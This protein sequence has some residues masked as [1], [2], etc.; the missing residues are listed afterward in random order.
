MT[1]LPASYGHG[2]HRKR[3]VV[4][5]GRPARN[6]TFSGT[7][8]KSFYDDPRNGA[9]PSKLKRPTASIIRKSKDADDEFDVPMSDDEV[10]SALSKSKKNNKPPT[11]T[12]PLSARGDGNDRSNGDVDSASPRKRK[13]TVSQTAQSSIVRP[14]A[15]VNKSQGVKTETE[16]V[17]VESAQPRRSRRQVATG[18]DST[19]APSS[20]N[21][22]SHVTHTTRSMGLPT[23]STCP[24]SLVVASPTSPADS[25]SSISTTPKQ[26]KLWHE[27]LLSD[28]PD[29]DVQNSTPNP[30][31][32]SPHRILNQPNASMSQPLITNVPGTAKARIVDRLKRKTVAA[33]RSDESSED[34]ANEPLEGMPSQTLELPRTSVQS[35]PQESTQH[36]QSQSRA[37]RQLSSTSQGAQKVTYARS[38]TY[39]QDSL[40]DMIFGDLPI[41]ATERPIAS[42]RRTKTS[43]R[44]IS[45]SKVSINHDSDEESVQGIRSIHDLRAAGHK[46]RFMDDVTRL[47]DDIKNPKPSTRSQRRMALMELSGTL[48]DSEFVSRFIEN[49]FDAS[50]IAQF[51]YAGMDVL[52]DMLLCVVLT[53]IAQASASLLQGGV[54]DFLTSYLDET[55]EINQIAR[56]RKSNM[57]KVAQSDYVDFME[58]FRSS[59]VWQDCSPEYLSPSSVA[60][61]SIN[62]IVVAHRRNKNSGTILSPHTASKLVSLA[63]NHTSGSEHTSQAVINRAL[64]TLEAA[65]TLDVDSTSSD[66]WSVETLAQLAA[67]LPQFLSMS[68]PSQELALRFCCSVTND[69][70]DNSSVFCEPHTIQLV[71]SLIID[72]FNSRN[73]SV[74]TELDSDHDLLVLALGLMIN[75]AGVS[76]AAREYA[77][78]VKDEG[79]AALV[80]IFVKGQKKAAESQSEEEMQAHIPYAWLSV[81]LGYI[82]LNKAIRARVSSWLPGENGAVL[83]DAVEGIAQMSQQVDSQVAEEEKEISSGFTQ[84]LK[85]LV[86]DL[87]DGV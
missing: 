78:R 76:D 7:S 21:T 41:D 1:T 80:D 81:L 67:A 82:C 2:D 25:V 44:T 64:S 28:P 9:S 42:A 39:L 84:K 54:L 36:S 6:S 62:C 86:A 12:S 71:V 24:L 47:L 43:P 49:G 26:K 33:H 13:R 59:D 27:L 14:L 55:K 19:S 70:K 11:K 29:E 87:R 77:A 58:K 10:T 79:F 34:E 57:S 38:R 74:E 72:G 15:K 20:H 17:T 85:A 30:M 66:V 45:K 52:A 16:K 35:V 48:A 5:Y 75:L 50:I 23:K 3:P 4:T 68:R 60:L 8:V 65:T 56:E 61:V 18:I 32:L 69:N 37:Q 40:E 73:T 63:T 53:R 46:S 51:Q 31:H 83:V 22:D